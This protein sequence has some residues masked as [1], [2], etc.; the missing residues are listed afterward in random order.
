MGTYMV[1][2]E[3]CHNIDC[4]NIVIERNKKTNQYKKYCSS[5]C[6]HSGVS[7]K[8]KINI[9]KEKILYPVIHKCKLC[10][11]EFETYHKSKIFCSENHR[12]EWQKIVTVDRECVICKSIF[13]VKGNLNTRICCSTVCA[14]ELRKKTSLNKYGT[15]NPSKSLEIKEKIKSTNLDRY[16]V[17]YTA[18]SNSPTR[19]KMIDTWKEKYGVDN[20]IKC[21]EIRQKIQK[22]ISEKFGVEYIFQSEEIKNK[23][24]ITNLERYG[25]ESPFSSDIIRGK[26]TNTLLEKY[27]VDNPM[28]CKSILDKAID[29]NRIRYERDNYTQISVSTESLEKL[30]DPHW[31]LEN[32][33]T[34]TA[35]EISTILNVTPE[36]VFKYFRK[37]NI[38]YT[39]HNTSGIESEIGAFI[40]GLYTGEI[41]FNSRSIID[42]RE[43]DIYIPEFKLAIEINGLYW[44]SELSQGKDNKYHLHKTQLCNEKG[45]RLIHVFENEWYER[46]DSIKSIILNSLNI[47]TKIYARNCVLREV[48]TTDAKKFL[49][50]NH[51]QGYAKSIFRIGLYYNDILVSIMTFGNSRYNNTVDIELIRF[52]SLNG[53]NIIGGAS[54]LF[55]YYI[56]NNNVDK[57]ISYSHKDKFTGNVYKKLGFE[58]SH[59]SSPSYY[60]TKDYIILENRLKYQKHK[61]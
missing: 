28:K 48:S 37:H 43:L 46:S 56:K 12:N 49:D 53:Y 55:Q 54:K 1:N 10:S 9:H 20:P 52:A 45:I 36:C 35:L 30:N 23:I 29:T 39:K 3:K 19:K 58:Y 18:S 32:N 16:G 50:I 24:K 44:H 8:L 41:L 34:K 21:D 4:D 2:G 61:L 6:R 33:A 5:F 51:I 27:G 42:N 60:Y 40:S 13:T 57:I 14:V 11:T 25:V 38:L 15:D 22:S 7:K 47:G 17:E 31:L 26:I 59:S